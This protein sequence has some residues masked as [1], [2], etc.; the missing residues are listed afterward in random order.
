M[1]RSRQSH[2]RPPELH[3]AAGISAA[4][5][6]ALPMAEGW[7]CAHCRARKKPSGVQYEAALGF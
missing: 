7:E 5:M 1:R 6:T 4:V 3:G 2:V